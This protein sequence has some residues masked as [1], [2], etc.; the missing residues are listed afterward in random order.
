MVWGHENNDHHNGSPRYSY[1]SHYG[2]R[3]GYASMYRNRPYPQ[4]VVVSNGSALAAEQNAANMKTA[5]YVGI[6]VLAVVVIGGVMYS[7]KK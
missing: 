2:P 3:S 5:L 7:R 6:G 4:T 1:S